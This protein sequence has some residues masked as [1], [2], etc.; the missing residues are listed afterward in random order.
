MLSQ[1]V[2]FPPLF[3]PSAWLTVLEMGLVWTASAALFVGCVLL[4][5]ARR[6]WIP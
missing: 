5:A 2:F 3:D 4:L 1:P 6:G